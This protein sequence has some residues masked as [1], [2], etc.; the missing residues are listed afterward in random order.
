MNKKTLSIN[1]RDIMTGFLL[2]AVMFLAL[3]AGG[4]QNGQ[5]RYQCC[6]AGDSELAVFVI[7]TQ[8]GETWRLGRSDTF[9]FGTPQQRKSLRQDEVPIVK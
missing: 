2:A 1:I 8:T 4:G 3:G 6:P 9:Y 5:G 7:D